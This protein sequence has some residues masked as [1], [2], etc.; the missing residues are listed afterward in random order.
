MHRFLMMERVVYGQPAAVALTEEVSR[1]ERRRVL[2]V[3]NRSLAT[4]KL[5]AV[6]M[7]NTSSTGVRGGLG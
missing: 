6:S 4:S 1:L 2:V 7:P 3:T 5:L